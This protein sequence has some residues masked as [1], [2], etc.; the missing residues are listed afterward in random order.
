MFPPP[1]P[2]SLPPSLP[3]TYLVV[4]VGHILVEVGGDLFDEPRG[5]V[6]ARPRVKGVE[7]ILVR[8][9]HLGGEPRE[10]GREGGRGKMWIGQPLNSFWRT[11]KMEG[12]SRR[13]SKQRREDGR[14]RA[15]E[16]KQREGG[17]EG[18][19]K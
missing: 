3:P 7:G 4:R 1:C 17:R 8:L 14:E 10:G 2:P 19:R 11:S 9:D 16:I 13:Q 12:R 15:E 5:C 18:Q 6:Q